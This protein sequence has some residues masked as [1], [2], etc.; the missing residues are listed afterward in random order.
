MNWI[1]N[2]A[3]WLWS[4]LALIVSSIAFA[5]FAGAMTKHSLDVLSGKHR[6]F[7]LAWKVRMIAGV[8]LSILAYGAVESFGLS[9]WTASA[10]ANLIGFA[11]IEIVLQLAL[12]R[13]RAL[14]FVNELP[15]K[16]GEREKG[17]A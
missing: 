11:G 12:L 17:Q 4:A 2:A 15:A 9:G 3:E 7:G 14:G 6:W 16:E 1:E 13:L 5:V 10:I 8:S